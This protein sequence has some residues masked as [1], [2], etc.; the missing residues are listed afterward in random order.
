MTPKQESI[1]VF[2]YGSLIW[3]TGPVVT[4]D[5][6]EGVLPGWHREWTW[7]SSTRHGAPTCSLHRGG[8]I[9]GV[10]LLLNPETVDDDLEEF[11]GREN[12]KT[13]ET[14]VD[15]PDRDATTYF[16]TMGNNLL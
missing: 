8:Q 14:I 2:G 5:R 3:G 16:W 15:V 10:F 12:R 13:E 11:R 7:I 1:W 4:A 9:R 6:R